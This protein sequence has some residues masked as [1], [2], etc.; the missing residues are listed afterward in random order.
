M[1]KSLLIFK[2]HMKDKTNLQKTEVKVI[3]LTG[4]VSKSL[5]ITN[6]NSHPLTR[7][8]IQKKS[9]L[10]YSTFWPV[11]YSTVEGTGG[12]NRLQEKDL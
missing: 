11:I 5:L 3:L 2:L 9:R 12:R 10:M 1:I 8:L 6:G 7:V 4:S